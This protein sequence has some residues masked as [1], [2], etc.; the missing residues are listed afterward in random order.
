MVPRGDHSQSS[1]RV[2]ISVSG[3]RAVRYV[4]EH[5]TQHT[6]RLPL[7]VPGGPVDVDY[8]LATIEGYSVRSADGRFCLLWGRESDEGEPTAASGLAIPNDDDLEHQRI[9]IK[10]SIRGF[11]KVSLGLTS[12]ISPNSLNT[13]RRVSAVVAQLR[14]PREPQEPKK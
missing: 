8:E 2:E 10:R 3:H 12:I 13:G 7:V 6:C 5:R 14:L 11:S 4:E 9:W 1:K